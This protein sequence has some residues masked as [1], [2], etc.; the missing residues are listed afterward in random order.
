MVFSTWIFFAKSYFTL[1][2]W[3]ASGYARLLAAHF[4]AQTSPTHFLGA[5]F[6][7]LRFFE[8]DLNRRSGPQLEKRN[9]R[10]ARHSNRVRPE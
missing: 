3:L 8:A 5:S 10:R 1:C 7:E 4:C 9:P 2:D 6:I